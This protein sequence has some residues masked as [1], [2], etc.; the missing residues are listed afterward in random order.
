MIPTQ[1]KETPCKLPWTDKEPLYLYI[2]NHINSDGILPDEY[3]RLPQEDIVFEN[4]EI[5][6]EAG[7]KEGLFRYLAGSTT[8]SQNAAKDIA[9]LI[10]NQLSNPGDLTRGETYAALIEDNLLEHIDL[11]LEE[12][13]E[14]HDLDYTILYEEA[15]WFAKNGVHSG[16]VKMGIALMS[17]FKCSQELDE[18][19]MTLGKHEE[20]TLYAGV[21]IQSLFEDHNVKLFELAK[22]VSGWGKICLVERIWADSEQIRDWLLRYGCENR[23]MNEY[24]AYTCA[25]KGDLD[26][27]L[28]KE[29]I[30]AQLFRG[31]S[32][33]IS[34]LISGGLA[35]DIYGYECAV[36]VITNYIRHA[37]IHCTSEQDLYVIEDIRKY[38]E[39]DERHGMPP[40]WDEESQQKCL[41]AIDSLLVRK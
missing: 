25:A 16:V 4:A 28:S 35:V 19:L 41:N 32:I 15:M 12:L 23:I 33:I 13:R 30:D 26:E 29:C 18:L 17:L 1:N 39:K 9:R 34:A 11:L 6:L 21:A 40:G 7:A 3:Q 5:R 14:K 10:K 24:L 8:D 36:P 27:A 37:A 31:A 2:K 20:F 22:C 38:V